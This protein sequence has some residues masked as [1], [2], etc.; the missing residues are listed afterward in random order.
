MAGSVTAPADLEVLVAFLNTLDQR[1]FAQH[2][3]R[4]EPHEELSSP[5]ALAR[6]LTE[7]GLTGRPNGRPRATDG[8]LGR[9]I[10]VRSALRDGLVAA[11]DA[12]RDAGLDDQAGPADSPPR[13]PRGRRASAAGT[14]AALEAFPLHLVVDRSGDLTLACTPPRPSVVNQGI[15][16]LVAAAATAGVRGTWDRVRVCAAADCRWAFLDASRRGDKRWCT[17]AVCGNRRKTSDYR[18]R[19]RDS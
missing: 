1:T 15:A 3:R 16:A 2:G 4:H 8:D 19:L 13:T 11:L 17:T 9:A 6:W 18:S 5:A 10:G 12:G 7:R 14:S